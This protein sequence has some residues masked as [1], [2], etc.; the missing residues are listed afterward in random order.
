MHAA[1]PPARASGEQTIQ[2]LADHGPA[3][4]SAGA[5]C[6]GSTEAR[7][8][9]TALELGGFAIA[10]TSERQRR[11]IELLDCLGD[12]DPRVRD[13][14]ASTALNI[15]LRGGAL[16]PATRL[17]LAELLLPMVEADEDPAGFR[18][19][20]AALALAEVA[21]AD[22]LAPTLPDD[23][24]RRIVSAATQ[25]LRS[26]RDYRGY[27]PIEGWRHAVAHGADLILQIGVHPATTEPE[28]RELIEAITT[29]LAPTRI[30]YV[31]GEPER[32]AR[33]VYFIHGRGIL[34]DRFWDAWFER[35]GSQATSASE[36]THREMHE[37]LARRHNLLAFLHA[38]AFAARANPGPASDRLAELAHR[39]LVRVHGG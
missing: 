13:G 27:D 24:R 37:Q 22:R 19:P 28:A 39:E 38:I 14:I 30:A 9:L 25:Y 26:T 29:Q 21:R 23:V 1:E 18:R 17:S 5:A 36:A 16:E 11:A 7:A 32:L 12:P 31:F 4:S 15:W 33:A 35:V 6:T 2:K 10:D 34:D 3:A 20:F 8:T